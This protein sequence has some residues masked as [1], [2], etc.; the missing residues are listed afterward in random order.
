[1]GG[2]PAAAGQRGSDDE[3][4]SRNVEPYQSRTGNDDLTGPLG[5]STPDVIGA[6]HSDEMVSSDYEQDQ[7]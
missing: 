3:E 6:T 4:R 5:E 2:S 1:M 7:F